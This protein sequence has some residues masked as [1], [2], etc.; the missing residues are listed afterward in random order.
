MPALVLAAVAVLTAALAVLTWLLLAG[1]DSARPPVK[2]DR[3]SQK[4][5]NYLSLLARRAKGW[6]LPELQDYVK[7]RVGDVGIYEM[8]KQDAS[9]L[10]EEFRS[11]QP[12]ETAGPRR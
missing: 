1:P 11:M 6:G 5:I 4:Q 7:N 8:S 2:N 10:I 9:M 12:A 3:V